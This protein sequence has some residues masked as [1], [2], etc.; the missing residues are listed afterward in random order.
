MNECENMFPSFCPSTQHCTPHQ[1][2][3]PSVLSGMDLYEAMNILTDRVNTCIR[4]YNDVMANCYKTLHNLE[5][6]CEENGAYYSPSDVWTEQGYDAQSGATYTLIHKN[7]LDRR[8]NP[9][10]VELALAYDNTTNSKITQTLDSTSKVKFSDK[11][12]VAQPVGENGWYGHAIWKGAPIKTDDTHSSLY[13][14]GFTRKGTMRVYQNAVSTDQ[15]IRDTIENAMGCSGVLINNGTVTDESWINKIPNYN[16]QMARICMGQNSETGEVI[17]LV[18]G[19]ENDV[20]KK[21]MTSSACANILAQYGCTTAV[22]LAEGDSAGAMDKGSLMF[23][24]DENKIPDVYCYWYISRKCYYNNDYERELAELMQNYG[25]CIWQG[26]LNKLSI[27]DVAT[28]LATE[29]NE[30][31]GADTALGERITANSNSIHDLET[32]I[33]RLDQITT[34]LNTHVNSLDA[35]YQNLNTRTTRLEDEYT[36]LDTSVDNIISGTTSLP[37]LRLYANKV[38]SPIHMQFEYRT[39]G[40][41][42]PIID[43]EIMGTGDNPNNN[44]YKVISDDGDIYTL[45]TQQVYS[46]EG[47]PISKIGFGY[48][49]QG[50]NNLWTD[51]SYIQLGKSVNIDDADFDP[52]RVK[53]IATPTEA[54]DAVNKDYIDYHLSSIDEVT[55]GNYP[56]SL[57]LN[58]C[59]MRLL[60]SAAIGTNTI[61]TPLVNSRV[62]ERL[63]EIL[64]ASASSGIVGYCVN[65]D[66]VRLDI[67]KQT[68]TIW[69][70][71]I[72]TTTGVIEGNTNL[73]FFM[74]A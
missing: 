28:N 19:K 33:D 44:Y 43:A 24:P 68:E 7:K 38:K 74:G 32:D 59:M 58:G 48:V 49:N 69:L 57:E 8:G 30:R 70:M 73:I 29:V 37:Y 23:I 65:K 31:I 16:V 53:G 52:V 45:F 63:T 26:Y 34:D 47:Q 61:T 14:V 3:V 1:P 35:N 13:T 51:D 18:C 6:A 21:G 4:T 50:R 25:S 20:N 46:G 40:K 67:V 27:A 55:T 9:I 12:V 62:V 17:F 15:L 41:R 11:I 42:T 56:F 66:N 22:E 36:E 2:P 5:K 39:Y 10:R 64:P 60:T 72:K 54:Y 71:T